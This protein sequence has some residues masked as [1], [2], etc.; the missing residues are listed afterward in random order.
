MTLFLMFDI[1]R[2]DRF[3]SD[4]CSPEPDRQTHCLLLSMA[5]VRQIFRGSGEFQTP[6]KSYFDWIRDNQSPSGVFKDITQWWN[7]WSLLDPPVFLELFSNDLWLILEWFL[8]YSRVGLFSLIL[9]DLWV[10]IDL[11]SS[12]PT[13]ILELSSSDHRI[14][15]RW[16]LSDLS[17]LW[18]ILKN[19]QGPSSDLP[20]NSMWFLGH[21]KMFLTCQYSMHHY[22]CHPLTRFKGWIVLFMHI[23]YNVHIYINWGVGP[24]LFHA[25]WLPVDCLD[26]QHVPSSDGYLL[27]LPEHREYDPLLRFQ[28]VQY[29]GS[30]RTWS[31]EWSGSGEGQRWNGKILLSSVWIQSRIRICCGLYTFGI[32]QI[33]DRANHFIRLIVPT[34]SITFT[35][36]QPHSPHSTTFTPFNHIHPIDLSLLLKYIDILR[37]REIRNSFL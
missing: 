8:S 29:D 14:I 21:S 33:W 2:V 11:S 24:K 35:H 5:D 37:M 22:S 23:W 10:T 25:G 15:F 20:L 18:M 30:G 34:Q 16:F 19:P 7:N 6:I 26:V 4:G 36:I 31:L 1:V 28:S 3:P 27:Q 17:D 9:S 32:V 12:N 13:V